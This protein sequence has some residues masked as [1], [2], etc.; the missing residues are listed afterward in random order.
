MKSLQSSLASAA[1]LVLLAS[2]LAQAAPYY[3]YLDAPAAAPEAP[4]QV[5]EAAGQM[6]EV[7]GQAQEA[8]GQT[9]AKQPGLQQVGP[10]GQLPHRIHGHLTDLYSHGSTAMRG[11]VDKMQ[12]DLKNIGKDLSEVYQATRSEMGRRIEP[13]A[14]TV[15]P[16]IDQAQKAVAPY[17]SQ[18]REE[19]PKLINQAGPA[20]SKVGDS[21]RDGLTGVWSKLNGAN[22]Q[23]QQL[24]QPLA[25]GAGQ[26]VKSVQD[27]IQSA[28]EQAK[29]H[30]SNTVAQAQ[31]PEA[32]AAAPAAQ[33]PA[34]SR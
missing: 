9:L 12:P 1:S 26:T 15:R 11:V 30:V 17:M 31:A 20:L 27:Q 22:Q 23:Q 5:A 2:C 7:A 18:A 14:Q 19:V 28:A 24:Q 34:A 3:F 33:A 6:Q 8:V 4:K 16:F 13:L 32:A 21:V 10:D 25:A 29:Q